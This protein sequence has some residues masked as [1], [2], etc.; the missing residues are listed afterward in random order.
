MRLRR[1]SE[2]LKTAFA[3]LKRVARCTSTSGQQT[4]LCTGIDLAWADDDDRK[5]NESGVVVLDPK[6]TIVSAGWTIGVTDTVALLRE[7]AAANALLFVDAPL[8]VNNE[9]GQRLC[10]KHVGQRY[11]RWGVSANSTNRHSPRLAG[12]DLIKQ[13][14]ALGW[15]YADGAQGPPTRPGRFVSECYPY[16]TIVGTAELG[17]DTERPRYKRKPKRMRI[18]E[19]RP[20][21]AAACDE[22]VRRVAA[23][24]RADPPMTLES[25]PETRRLVTEN[26]PTDDKAYKHREDQLDAAICAWTAALWLRWGTTRCQVLGVGN[27]SP[28][29]RLATIIAHIRPV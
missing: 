16:T 12:V 19:F 4:K 5:P 13:L 22:L 23:L 28:G 2:T 9:T 26:S 11:W 20:L 17:Y 18:A 14:S 7:N 3:F 29:D 24:K 8:V 21:R 27:T 15:S 25:H 6:G 1:I 10:E